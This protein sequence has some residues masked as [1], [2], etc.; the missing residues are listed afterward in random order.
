MNS[1]SLSAKPRRTRPSWWMRK[2]LPWLHAAVDPSTADFWLQ[3]INPTWSWQRSLAR[4]VSISHPAQGYV[5]VVLRPNKHFRGFKAGQH[6]NLS[7]IIHGRR[8]TRS[9]S[10]TQPPGADGL[11]HLTV[12]HVEGGVLSSHLCQHARVGDVLELS[13]PFG[14]MRLAADAQRHLLLAAGSGITPLAALLREWAK[15]PASARTAPLTLVYWARTQAELCFAAEFQALAASQP[16]FQ[17]VP[18]LTHEAN[19]QACA[20]HNQLS[21]ELLTSLGVNTEDADVRTC[22][23]S[24]FVQAVHSVCSKTRSVEAEGFTPPVVQ[25][26]AQGPASVQV[27][28]R[29]SR[30]KLELSTNL[31]L[32]EALEQAGLQPKHGC[33]M[34]VCHTCVCVRHDGTTQNLHDGSLDAEMGR[35]VRLCVSRARTDLTLDL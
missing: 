26:D 22:G 11:L 10:F 9:Y 21:P 8:I 17:F 20:E 2:A 3:R 35:E 32:L 13:R 25:A 27:E 16:L 24:G 28:L 34:G 19:G 30:K 23:P 4:I 7:A 31:S 6:T 5:S 1:V 18:V 14:N 12:R 29:R 15:Q 33:R